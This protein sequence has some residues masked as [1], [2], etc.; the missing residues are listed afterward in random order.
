MFVIGNGLVSKTKILSS[1]LSGATMKLKDFK[2]VENIPGIYLIK[3]LVNN[4]CYIGQSIR[5]KTRLQ[6]HYSTAISKKCEDQ[7]AR[8]ILYSAIEKYGIDNFEVTILYSEDTTE[9]NKVKRTLDTLEK[10][11]IKEYKSQVPDGYNQT[12]GGDAGVLGLKM[13]E[14]QKSVISKNSHEINTDGRFLI[15]CYD[16]TT[17]YYY[18][19]VSLPALSII[20]RIE[21]STSDLRHN[22]IKGRYL[23]SRD[24]TE[25]ENKIENF[26]KLETRI[27]G[28]FTSKLTE[29][30][31]E[32][33]KNGIKQ[34]DFCEKYKVCKKTFYNYRKQI[35]E[36]KP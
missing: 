3:N 29:E 26:S 20:L 18:T 17:K 10:K 12:S 19:A 11:Y 31:K 1:S 25:L 28:K 22:I 14:E 8:M 16:T 34:K 2:E 24:K 35:L 9:F 6:D 30:Q 13:T 5:L 23:I 32:D 15:Y 33:I 4:K 7:K 21:L 27:L 36:E